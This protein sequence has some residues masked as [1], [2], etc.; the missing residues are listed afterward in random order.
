[1]KE[2]FIKLRKLAEGGWEGH[3]LDRL[4]VVRAESRFR[5]EQKVRELIHHSIGTSAKVRF[6]LENARRQFG[7]AR[8]EFTVPD[9]FDDPLNEIEDLFY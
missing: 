2:V 3:S 1:M 7:S 9:D 4:V 6:V 8:G 5:V